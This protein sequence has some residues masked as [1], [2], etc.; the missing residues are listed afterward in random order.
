ML[1][2][3]TLERARVLGCLE[4]GVLGLALGLLGRVVF[5]LALRFGACPLVLLCLSGLLLGGPALVLDSPL[6]LLGGDLVLEAFALDLRFGL[7]LSDLRFGIGPMRLFRLLAGVELGVG[8]GVLEP[9][10]AGKLLLASGR[11]DHLLYF[12]DDLA[13]H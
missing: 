1:A 6:A 12:A 10:L 8:L 9:A 4:P 7:L 3:L 13:G 2:C 5:G 11:A